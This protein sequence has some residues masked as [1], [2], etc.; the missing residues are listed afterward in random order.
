MLY[1]CSALQC[2][3]NIHEVSDDKT[4]TVG[5]NTVKRCTI[6]EK[7]LIETRNIEKSAAI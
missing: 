6:L 2:C 7:I 3:F 4:S 1:S 5:V